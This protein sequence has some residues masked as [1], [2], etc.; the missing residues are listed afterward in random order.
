MLHKQNIKDI[1]PLSPMQESMLFHSLMEPD[2]PA[3]FEQMSFAI[4]GDFNTELF[5]QSIDFLLKRHDILRTLFVHKNVS[6]PFQVVLKEAAFRVEEKDLS[7]FSKENQEQLINELKEKD[8]RRSFQ[9]SAEILL[10]IQ[11]IKLGKNEYRVIWSHHHI[12]MDGWCMGIIVKEFLDVYKELLAGRTPVLPAVMP[13]NSYI[14]WLEKQNREESLN[15]WKSYLSDVDTA[16]PVPHVYKNVQSAFT[17][18]EIKKI[19]PQALKEQLSALSAELGITQNSCL[20]ALWGF[21]LAKM[22]YADKAVFGVVVSGR[23]SEITNVGSILGLFINTIPLKVDLTEGGTVKEFLQG[24]QKSSNS[25]LGHEYIPLADIQNQSGLG[26]QLFDHIFIYENFPAAVNASSVDKSKYGFGISDIE[27]YEQTN[28]NLNVVVIPTNGKLEFKYDFNASVYSALTIE[29]L[30]QR[31]E[32]LLEQ[33]VKKPG[34]LLRDLDLRIATDHIE[35]DAEEFPVSKTVIDLIDEKCAGQQNKIAVE[36]GSLKISYRELQEKANALS[37][38]LIHKYNVGERDIVALYLD[39]SPEAVI[40]I[41][42]VLKAGAL[43]VPIDK[44]N[45]EERIAFIIDDCKAK[46]ILTDEEKVIGQNCVNIKKLSGTGAVENINNTKLSNRAYIIYTSGSTGNPKGCGLSHENLSNYINWSSEYY[47]AKCGAPADFPLYTSLSFDLTITS[48]FLPLITGRTLTIYDKEIT[49]EETLKKIF[50]NPAIGMVKIT[51]AHITLLAY[52]GIKNSAVKG[53]VVGGEELKQSHVEILKNIAPGIIIFNEYGPT[54]TTVGCSVKVIRDQKEEITIG[55][56]IR[57]MQM[58]IVDKELNVLPAGATGEIIILGTGVGLGYLNR[59]ELSAEKFISLNGKK[60]YRSGDLGKQMPDGEFQFL[61]RIDD[62]VKIRGYRVEPGE[63]EK[64]LLAQKKIREACV[65]AVKNEFLATYISSEEE[66]S[67][68]ALRDDLKKILPPYMVPDRII[69]VPRIPLTANGKVDKKVLLKID[70]GSAV[71]YEVPQTETEEQLSKIWKEVLHVERA[72]RTDN[73][74]HL[75]GHSLKITI[76]SSLIAKNFKKEISIKKLYSAP[77]LKDQARLIDQNDEEETILINKAAP[78]EYYPLSFAQNRLFILHQLEPESTAYNIPAFLHLKGNL[79]VEKVKTSFEAIF[80]KHEIFRTSFH[81]VNDVP[82]QKVHDE[83]KPEFEYLAPGAEDEIPA[84][85]Q[86]IRPFDLSAAPLLRIKI[87]KKAEREYILGIDMHHIVS[88]GVSMALLVDEFK[89]LYAEQETDAAGIQYRDFAVWQQKYSRTDKFNAHRKYWLDQFSDPAEPLTLPY[90]AARPDEQRYAGETQNFNISKEFSKEIN[91]WITKKDLSLFMFLLS[92]FKLLLFK[93]SGQKDLT[94]GVPVSG[95]THPDIQKTLGVFI[96]T[97]ALRT[98]IID[99]YSFDDFAQQ[100]KGRFLESLDHQDFPFEHLVEELKIQPDLSRNPLFDIMFILQNTDNDVPEMGDVELYPLES[101]NTSAKF[102][103]TLIATETTKGININ[104]EYN[105]DL[106]ERS[107]IERFFSHYLQLLRSVLKNSGVALKNYALLNEQEQQVLLSEKTGELFTHTSPETLITLFKKNFEEKKNKQLLFVGNESYTCNELDKLSDCIAAELLA[108]GVQKEE[109]V[110][111]KMGRGVGFIA[112]ML[113]VMKAGAAYVSI[114]VN[115]PADRQEYIIRDSK[116]SVIIGNGETLQSLP[117]NTKGLNY[118]DIDFSKT[119]KAVDRSAHDG[120]AY[121]IYT[122]GS[123]GLPKGVA[124][125]HRNAAS[126]VEW[127]EKEFSGDNYDVVFAGTSFSF[128][129]SIFEIFYHLSAGKKIR[130][131]ESG[132]EISEYLNKEKNILLNTVPS[133]INDLQNSAADFSNVAA[134]NM[135]GEP[136]PSGVKNRLNYKKTKVRNLYGPSE[137]TTYSTFYR[138]EEADNRQIIGKPIAGTKAYVLDE[139]LQLLPE[140]IPGE[141]YLSG[142]GVARGYLNKE[143]I[144]KERFLP[145]PFAQGQRMYKTGDLVR[146][147]AD[148]D[149]EYLGRLD[150]QVKIRGYRIELGEIE[151]VIAREFD[152]KEITVA[153]MKINDELQL[154][155][156]VVADAE[157]SEAG[158]KQRLS[159]LLPAYMVPLYFVQLDKLPLTSNGKIDKRKLPL[160]ASQRNNNN[161][162]VPAGPTGEKLAL[163]WSEVLGVEQV[164]REDNFF[165]LGGHSLKA[166]V[167]AAKLMRIFHVQLAIKD[168]FKNPVLQRMAE[169]IDQKEKTIFSVIPAAAKKT[170]YNVSSSQKRIFVLQQLDPES[171]QYNMT[172]VLTLKGNVDLKKVEQSFRTIANRHESLRTNFDLVDGNPVQIIHEKVDLKIDVERR[173]EWDHTILEEFVRPYDLKKDVLCRI[174]IIQTADVYYLLFDI[175]HIV[176]DGYSIKNFTSE[177]IDAYKGD[178]L[179]ELEIQYKDFSEWQNAVFNSSKLTGQKNYWLEKFAELPEPLDLPTDYKRPA[180]QSYAGNELKFDLPAGLSKKAEQLASQSGTTLFNVLLSAYYLLLYRYSHKKDLVVGTP[181]SGRTY[182][183]LEKLIGVFINTLALRNEIG[184]GRFIEFLKQVQANNTDAFDRQDYPFEELLRALEL[185]RDLSRT[186]LFETMFSIE[187]PENAG[188]KL[189]DVEI[190]FLDSAAN[191]AKFD[192]TLIAVPD[193]KNLSFRIEYCTELFTAEYIAQFFEHY[194]A[195][196]E[197]VCNNSN[198][199]VSEITI[200]SASEKNCF[201]NKFNNYIPA[202]SADFINVFEKN[203][204]KFSANTAGFDGAEYTYSD[205]NN[206]ANQVANELKGKEKRRIGVLLEPGFELVASVLGI[207][208]S[209]NCYVPLDVNYPAERIEFILKDA[210]IDSVISRQSIAGKVRLTNSDFILIEKIKPNKNFIS[211]CSPDDEAYIIYTSGSTG[212]PK[213]VLIKQHQL[214]AKLRGIIKLYD[215]GP[216]LALLRVTN[217]TFDVSFLELFM[218][219][220][221]GGKT[222]FPAL[223]KIHEHEYLLELCNQQAVTDFQCTP[224]FLDTFI[225]VNKFNALDHSP[226]KNI[227]VGGESLTASLVNKVKKYLP[228]V[229]LNN[230]YG[231]TETTIDAI[232]ETDIHVFSQNIIGKPMPDNFVL[233]LDENGIPVPVG[234]VGEI[235]IGGQSVSSGYLNREAENKKAFASVEFRSKTEKLYRTGDLGKWTR[236]GKVEFFGRKDDQVKIRGHRIEPGEIESRIAAIEGVKQAAVLAL[237]VN[238]AI[239][240]CAYV[241]G[242]TDQQQII[243]ALARKIPSYM[244]PAHFVFMTQLPLNKNGKIDRKS[245]PAPNYLSDRA[246]KGARSGKEEILCGIFKQVLG[247]EQISIDDDFFAL[248][249]DSIKAIQVSSRFGNRGFKIQVRDIFE[250]PSIEK[251]ALKAKEKAVFID[252]SPVEGTAPLTAIQEYFL[253]HSGFEK[254][255]YNQSLLLHAEDGFDVKRLQSALEKIVLHHDALRMVIS[256]GKLLNKASISIELAVHDLRK[257][258]DHA[259]VITSICGEQQGSIDIEKGPLFKFIAFRTNQGD[260]LALIFH[261][262]VIDGVSWRILLEDLQTLYASDAELP[263]KTN[264]FIRWAADVNEY[265]VSDSVNKNKNY[266]AE[267]NAQIR[268]VFTIKNNETGD[269][270]EKVIFDPAFTKELLTTAN[271]KFNTRIHELLIAALAITVSKSTGAAKVPVSLEGHGREPILPQ[272]DISR[273]IGW[274]TSEYPVLIDL[275]KDEPGSVLISTKEH[276][277]NIPNNGIDHGILKYLQKKELKDAQTPQVIFNY[278]GDFT[279]EEKKGSFSISSVSTGPNQA[280]NNP[281]AYAL[282]INSF[283]SANGLQL[284]FEFDKKYFTKKDIEKFVLLFKETTIKLREF[285][286]SKGSVLTPSDFGLKNISFSV[287]EKII[288]KYTSIEEMYPLSPMQQG[289]LFENL[290]GGRSDDAYFEQSIVAVKGD[291]RKEK[292]EEIYNQLIARHQVLRSNIVY[293][294]LEQ[295]LSVISKE[296]FGNVIYKDLSGLGA[297]EQEKAISSFM[298]LEKEQ[299]YDLSKDLLM[300]IS[301]F[302]TGKNDYKILWTHHHI[303]ID[304]WCLGILLNEFFLLYNENYEK[305]L[306]VHSYSSYIS[307]LQKQDRITAEA[308]WKNLLSGY[309]TAVRIPGYKKS[310]QE[311]R[312]GFATEELVL[313][314]KL[315]EQITGFSKNH[316]LTL[317]NIIQTIWGILLQKYNSRNEVVFGSVISGRPADLEGVEN[318]VGLF[319]NTVPVKVGRADSFSETVKAVQEQFNNSNDHGYLPLNEIQNLSPLKGDLID[320]LLI[321]ESYPLDERSKAIN[322]EE[323]SLRIEGIE[324]HE[325]TNYDF[326]LT[327]LPT[328]NLTILFDYNKDVYDQESIRMIKNGFVTVMEQVLNNSGINIK[329]IAVCNEKETAALIAMNPAAVSNKNESFSEL[330]GNSCRKYSG[331][332]ALKQGRKTMTYAELDE[333]SNRVANALITKGIRSNDVVAIFARPCFEMM[334][335]ILGI[336]KSGAAYLP[337]DLDYPKERIEYMLEDSGAKFVLS[338]ENGFPATAGKPELLSLFE[339]SWKGDNSAAPAV[340]ISGQDSAYI[341]YTSGSTGK[342]KGVLISQESFV[343]YVEFIVRQFSLNE[344]DTLLQHASIAFDTTIEELYPLLS[345]GGKLIL[346]DDKKDFNEMLDHFASGEVTY[347]CT[348]PLVLNYINEENRGLGNLRLITVGGEELKASHVDKI[349]DKVSIWNGYGP[350]E[351]TVCATYYKVK[352][353]ETLIPIGTP[354]TGRE[355]YIIN[356]DFNLLPKGVAGELC[357]GGKGLA[358]KYLNQPELTAEKFIENPFASGKIYRTGDL[359]KWNANN[360]I[361]FLGRIDNQIQIRGFRVELGEV[362]NLINKMQSVKE[363]VVI[364]FEDEAT[365]SKYLCAYVSGDAQE[366]EIKLFLS[367][368]LPEYMIPSRFVRLEKLPLTTNGK[369]DKKALPKPESLASDEMIAL[370]EDQRQEMLLDIWK[371]VLKQTNIGIDSNFFSLGGDSIKAIQL[372]SRVRVHNL[373]LDIKDI[374][375]YPTVRQLTPH[376]QEAKIIAEQGLVN[377]VYPLTPIQKMFFDEHLAYQDHYNQAVMLFV[378]SRMEKSILENSLK[379]L[380]EHHDALR[381]RFIAS[382]DETV[383]ELETEITSFNVHEF[384]LEE[385]EEIEKKAQELQ[386]TLDI[387]EGKLIVS[388]LFHSSAGTH[389]LLAIHHLVVDGVSW[390][391]I[392]EDLGNILKGQELPAKTQSF[393]S[394]SLALQEYAGS[395]AL[396]KELPYWKEILENYKPAWGKQVNNTYKNN[397]TAELELDEEQTATLLT[398]IHTAYNTEI[399]DVLLAAL[400]MSLQNLLQRPDNLIFLEGHGREELFEAQDLS[401]TVGWFTSIFPVQLKIMSQQPGEIIKHTKENLRKIPNK[402]IGYG[403]LRFMNKETVISEELNALPE[404]TFNYLGQFEKEQENDQIRISDFSPGYAVNQDNQKEGVID[405]N[406]IVVNGK[407]KIEA[408]YNPLIIP[409]EKI[410]G[411]I[412]DYKNNL[413][414]LT[415]HCM[416]KEGTE[417]T[418]SDFQTANLSNEELDD[419]MQMMDDL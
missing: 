110:G 357:I 66:I 18:T 351:S 9:L 143:N 44:S 105:T 193:K 374:F 355:A 213:G 325:L 396:K 150:N 20:Q 34:M 3:Y 172:Y 414:L 249:G 67:I 220:I 190:G 77:V 116:A 157:I 331:N 283:V 240:L 125:E 247:L 198:V 112:G 76:L 138:V 79:D 236:D 98:R 24:V 221:A 294:E 212:Q 410:R 284:D 42:A 237:T 398:K 65:I 400:G 21:L 368:E 287:F 207:W 297:K 214:I 108:L 246:I 271:K 203:L 85:Q 384:E 346:P 344:K 144:T 165:M 383:Q 295:P 367:N 269:G 301:L 309:D 22:N 92:A 113:G 373:K 114:D 378:E 187:D 253:N 46:L 173:A 209:G 329:E 286:L 289:M 134:I 87:I 264:S 375:T 317:F 265:A 386:G 290:R 169:L 196:L 29:T 222:V 241:V 336:I 354:F 167:L 244:I 372:A 260:Y 406:A 276:L 218:P 33:V 174:K 303:L 363:A 280:K 256:E 248:G 293:E 385:K 36:Y 56:A 282:E 5:K 299:G 252:Q 95:R 12:L 261:H 304:G 379:K 183:G 334:E 254:N 170:H 136:I 204:E 141:L 55:K 189:E 135:A 50:T 130:L 48:I 300:S 298:A 288:S 243:D 176:F 171:V 47:P 258:K 97:L 194:K 39:R 128:D 330:F 311:K 223:E 419:I 84:I 10:R 411:F 225:D 291:L 64:H 54:E 365:H 266:W 324:S 182:P 147:N 4:S 155:A 37:R 407:M 126:F 13:F 107:F 201:E 8:K 146:W 263:L 145:D 93:Y 349:I 154:C 74:F 40:A 115:Y 394:W 399:N 139:H 31:L 178:A 132:I 127:A 163:L 230:H 70:A 101:E 94:V 245:L 89:K 180:L 360:D 140:G 142:A 111:I 233:I 356:H 106:F 26:S 313:S 175:H 387:G 99:E 86:M 206:R 333:R 121:I 405:V 81:L 179:T 30:H 364:A 389:I 15:H 1:Y 17:K 103:I 281:V 96:N 418:A 11:L 305:L 268:P 168:I 197:Q 184:E 118:Q 202:E 347:F 322:Q 75:G 148:W 109:V 242:E 229:R 416:Q 156:Y 285:C 319:I 158:I 312:S 164:Y 259:A 340:K 49:V 58:Q 152:V 345:V 273:T 124:I 35:T 235:C 151:S 391:I 215:F 323:S 397:S 251:L 292:I 216:A 82:V 358:I 409:A 352:A 120:L 342:P 102:D 6:R 306:P 335:G 177:F 83:L 371:Q 63:I 186:P 122:S 90:K 181:V 119:V 395:N 137:D 199:P 228:Q 57:N 321:Y 315:Q 43:Y 219:L 417:Q 123:T 166:T 390:R 380:I 250:N 388:G 278:L 71:A 262:L 210:G 80:K 23:P 272:T 52:S 408:T 412:N 307:W 200:L 192:I 208:K 185:K 376:L 279:Q 401:R 339:D 25:T 195:I 38:Q 350:T 205:L 117:E 53:A 413:L 188:L 32:R 51:P 161:R 59:E 100:L 133:V 211:F 78:Q 217:P 267:L 381:T 45:P 231:P 353:N 227:C 337:V 361:D 239:A 402:G 27:T 348:S 377:G 2:S 238:N 316:Q 16:T 326:T 61:G 366:E 314:N 382:A 19:I 403:L 393:K 338:T 162:S 160:P 149:L 341:I 415:E 72:G 14:K 257:E 328:D 327:I 362:E 234:V 159:E 274:F 359:V 62:Q 369:V 255:H 232:I 7:S 129:L 277:R 343:G 392:L 320:H 91:E 226:L 370:P 224:S 153:A 28:Y 404:I 88:D 131:L 310:V 104:I 302:K 318:M 60:A 69:Q 68:D 332:V 308:Y 296:K 191:T 275:E 270:S 73:F 41:L